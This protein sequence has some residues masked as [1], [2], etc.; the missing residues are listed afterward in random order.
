MYIVGRH[1]GVGRYSAP[2]FPALAQKCSFF[3]GRVL[4]LD[5]DN[6]QQQSCPLHQDG[7]QTPLVVHYTTNPVHHYARLHLYYNRTTWF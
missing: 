1:P 4:D 7:R 6:H 3:M 2:T 5:G